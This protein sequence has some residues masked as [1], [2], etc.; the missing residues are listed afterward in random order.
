[1]NQNSHRSPRAADG[2]RAGRGRSFPAGNYDIPRDQTLEQRG[3]TLFQ[4][5][6]WD[7]HAH[8]APA[9]DPGA[10]QPLGDHGSERG[11]SGVDAGTHRLEPQDI[12]LP[13]TLLAVQEA[14]APVQARGRVRSHEDL[15]QRPNEPARRRPRPACAVLSQ[16]ARLSATPRSRRSR[17]RR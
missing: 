9:T 15:G 17:T 3:L 16:R 5:A 4:V 11:V 2:R 1:M 6:G 10:V 12:H 13:V 7:R 8:D 14:A